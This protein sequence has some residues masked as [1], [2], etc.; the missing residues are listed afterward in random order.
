MKRQNVRLPQRP[1]PHTAG[2]Q[3]A[4]ERTSS[5]CWQSEQGGCAAGSPEFEKCGLA[6]TFGCGSSEPKRH[7][8]AL[9]Y[10]PSDL[11]RVGRVHSLDVPG[12]ARQCN[13]GGQRLGRRIRQA[14]RFGGFRAQIDASLGAVA[15]KFSRHAGTC[16]G[17]FPHPPCHP[18]RPTGAS[19][20]FTRH[21]S[22]T[23]RQ[24]TDRTLAQSEESQHTR[25][26]A[27][28]IGKNLSR[29]GCASCGHAGR[30]C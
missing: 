13:R 21:V 1:N 22:S 3:V 16:N 6:T 24:G 2:S 19:K 18:F 27:T 30:P 25:N 14:W 23:Q 26:L 29:L 11:G 7:H 12:G 4:A 20:V 28:E 9:G 17:A 5:Y 10:R 15:R 8:L